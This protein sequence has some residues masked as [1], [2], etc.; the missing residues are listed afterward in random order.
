MIAGVDNATINPLAGL[1]AGIQNFGS[2]AAIGS[3]SMPA[4]TPL[5]TIP[6]LPG[7][8]RGTAAI[9]GY[10]GGNGF[11]GAGGFF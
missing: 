1:G 3:Y 9:G 4:V 8:L 7:G 11:G 2:N 10:L 5:P 6:V